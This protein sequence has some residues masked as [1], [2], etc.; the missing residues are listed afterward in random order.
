[1][2]WKESITQLWAGVVV[3]ARHKGGTLVEET[4]TDG[5]TGGF[6]TLEVGA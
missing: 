3:I 1:M 6:R 4:L 2:Q 5:S